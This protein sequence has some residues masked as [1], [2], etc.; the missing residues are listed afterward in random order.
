MGLR[1]SNNCA[2]RLK[3]IFPSKLREKGREERATI[4]KKKVTNNEKKVTGNKKNQ[5]AKSKE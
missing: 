5:K 3:L 4:N 2:F 1:K